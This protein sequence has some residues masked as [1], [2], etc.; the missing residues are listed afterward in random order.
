MRSALRA[1]AAG[2]R[3]GVDTTSLVGNREPSPEPD[4]VAARAKPTANA[5]PVRT[6][7]WAGV[8]WQAVV[9]GESPTGQQGLAV[10]VGAARGRWRAG[11]AV[12]AS[13]PASLDDEL[14]V[15]DLS[16][17]AA[18][19]SIGYDLVRRDR[20]QLEVGVAG[21]V[22]GYFRSTVT[23]SP[24]V[25]A[26]PSTVTAAGFA[27]PQARL[28]W[29]VAASHERAWLQLGVAADVVF[30]APELGYELDGAFV[31]RNQLWPL[32]PRFLVA[33]VVETQ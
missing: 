33:F 31:V 17:D 3:I 29:Q 14:T 11:I 21:G 28:R 25:N 6:R 24:A 7:W 19:I 12:S 5:E 30:G 18:G 27:S 2:G 26:T 4:V 8:G 9:D 1:L 16:R 10:D 23:L 13:L 15:V 22:A 32:Q 20:V